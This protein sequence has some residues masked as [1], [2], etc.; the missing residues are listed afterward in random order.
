MEQVNC[1]T[2]YVGLCFSDLEL[3]SNPAEAA[4]YL[5]NIQICLCFQ[6]WCISRLPIDLSGFIE[7]KKRY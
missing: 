7:V 5:K 3:K 2:S 6:A 4:W 1:A